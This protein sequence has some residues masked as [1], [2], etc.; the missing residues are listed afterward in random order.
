MVIKL[1]SEKIIY[2]H[3]SSVPAPWPIHECE[4]MN[5][6]TYQQDMRIIGT[7]IVKIA[8]KCYRRQYTDM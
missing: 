5:K 2:K 4:M 7:M 3:A 8:A 6:E 1:V